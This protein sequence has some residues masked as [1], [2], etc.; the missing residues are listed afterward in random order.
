MA[1]PGTCVPKAQRLGI[2]GTA[3]G[4]AQF[5]EMFRG[6]TLVVELP[7]RKAGAVQKTALPLKTLG[8]KAAQFAAL[9]TGK[10]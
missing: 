9:C 10:G 5:L 2:G 6:D 7:G 8:T 3:R 4:A 1:T